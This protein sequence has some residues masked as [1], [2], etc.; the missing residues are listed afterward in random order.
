MQPRPFLWMGFLTVVNYA[1]CSMA[2]AYIWSATCEQVPA[3]ASN[4]D[5]Y[6]HLK[7]MRDWHE[8]YYSGGRFDVPLK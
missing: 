2:V 3:H 1:M 8:V 7:C 5:Q 4:R 6:T